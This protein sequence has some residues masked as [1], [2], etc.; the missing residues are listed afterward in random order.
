MVKLTIGWHSDVGT[1]RCGQAKGRGNEEK[2]RVKE[3]MAICLPCNDRAWAILPT[4][5]VVVGSI[6]NRNFELERVKTW[7]M[8]KMGRG[9][10]TKERKGDNNMGGKGGVLDG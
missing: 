2:K 8:A 3:Y 6:N 10:G 1:L 7:S 4:K 9:T 5:K